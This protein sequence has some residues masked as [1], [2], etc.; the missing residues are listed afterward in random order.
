MREI[1]KTL[2]YEWKSK[3]LPETKGRG[4]DLHRYIGKPR[5]IIVISG[6]RRVGKT[7]LVFE[8][9]KHLLKTY[10]REEVIYINF[11]DERIPPKKEFLTSLI[12]VIKETFSKKTKILFLD[13]LQAIDGW[14]KWLRR[15]YDNQDFLIFV[16]G[17]SSKLS[18]KEIPTELRGRYLNIELFPLSFREFLRFKDLQVNVKEL[19]HNPDEKAKLL[20][21]LGDYVEFG[22]LPE[23][24]LAN[25]EEK[26]EILQNYYK[27]VVNRDIIERFNVKN[28]EGIKSLLRLLLN[29]TSYSVN[30]LYNIM[31][32]LNMKIGKT[33]LL[34]YVSYIETSYFLYSVMLFSRKIKDQLQYPKKNYFIDNGFISSLSLKFSDNK[35][36]LYENLVFIDLKRRFSNSSDKDIYYWRSQEKEEVDFLI[37]NGTKV[38]K[39]IQVCYDIDDY[40]TRKRE[41]KAL[42]KASKELKCRNLIVITY[43]KEGEEKVN[44]KKIKYISIW[45]YLLN[46]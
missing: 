46:E 17:S 27:T 37:K 32:S 18:T 36:R 3:K 44:S 5:K 42:L 9:I 15:V 24:V 38:E 45:K 30:K 13:E 34:N 8:F 20:R 29:S 1:I 28:E 33:A 40:D 6:F 19:D 11:E 31:K 12:P 4:I 39:L 16:T 10:N 2:L 22:G 35:S 21:A 25:E 26:R 14:S 23:V 43:D 41:L 7:Y